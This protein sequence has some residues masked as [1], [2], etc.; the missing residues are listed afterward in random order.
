MAFGAIAILVVW[1]VYCFFYAVFEI[2]ERV[3]SI[4]DT[5][6]LLIEERLN[7]KKSDE[8]KP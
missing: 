8:P 2:C 7:K 4:D 6:K 3:I 1:F 5:L